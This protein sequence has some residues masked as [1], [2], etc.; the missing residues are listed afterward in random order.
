M[1]KF[2]DYVFY[3]VC[4][5]YSSTKDS[6]P[7]GTAFCVVAGIQGFNIFSCFMIVEVVKQHKS[8]LKS[9]I[10]IFIA[11][12]LLVFNYVRYIYYENNNYQILREKWGNEKHKSINGILVLL[13]VIISTL[14]CI[15]LAIFLGTKN[16]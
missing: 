7:E 8:I 4:K 10:V 9:I 2:F 6:S 16:Y 11:V 5:A 3:R 13:Y 14:S 12:I 15:G 1:L